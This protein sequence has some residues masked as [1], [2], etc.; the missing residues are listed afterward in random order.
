MNE[1][2]DQSFVQ[3]LVYNLGFV[4]FQLESAYIAYVQ[5]YRKNI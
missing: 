5:F 4:M 3:N 2:N 1:W